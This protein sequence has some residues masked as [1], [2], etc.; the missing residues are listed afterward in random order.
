MTIVPLRM[1][2]KKGRA[3]IEL[4]LGKGKKNFDKRETLKKKAVERE[5][6]IDRKRE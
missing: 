6:E 3:K 1:Y 2:F 5:M 4:G